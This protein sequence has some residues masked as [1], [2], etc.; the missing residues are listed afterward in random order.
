MKKS[1]DD[2]INDAYQLF[3]CYSVK[4]PLDACTNCCITKEQESKLASL[5][6]KDIPF[7]LLYDYNVAAKA[8]NPDINELKHFLPRILELTS[9][10]EFISHSIEVIFTQFD[11]FKPEQWTIEEKEL[12]Q[13]FGES[14][15]RKCLKLF[16]LP[17]MEQIDS[18][19]IMLYKTGIDVQKLFDIWTK[20]LNQTSLLHFNNLLWNC[21]KNPDSE[22]LSNGFADDHLSTL[23]FTWSNQ[24][25]KLIQ[26]QNE[27][28]SI[29]MDSGNLDEWTLN[30]LNWTYDRLN[31]LKFERENKK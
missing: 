22:I 3:S 24:D 29:I 6:V 21:F 20:E 28:E 31:K 19:L 13:S 27:I 11:S 26:F 8:T 18:I 2:I 23:I 15:F 17:E 25:Y 4:Q 5:R 30:E 16:P 12:I 14:F 7:Q 10:F 1:L 9:K